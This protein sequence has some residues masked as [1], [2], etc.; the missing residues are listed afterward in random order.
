MLS[1]KLGL[2]SWAKGCPLA[3][4]AETVSCFFLES[5]CTKY[6]QQNPAIFSHHSRYVNHSSQWQLQSEA[7]CFCSG[8][9][10]TG[11]SFPPSHNT[12]TRAGRSKLWKRPRVVIF[13][14]SFRSVPKHA[15]RYPIGRRTVQSTTTDQPSISR[16]VVC[17]I[18]PV[19]RESQPQRKIRSR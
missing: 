6:Q 3:V 8:S 11:S 13:R 18:F 17:F 5:L 7:I 16:H 10:K 14:R 15:E 4:N 9:C 19:Q 2:N 1:W 12:P